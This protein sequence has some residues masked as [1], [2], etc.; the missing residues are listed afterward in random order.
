MKNIPIGEVLRE[1][2]YISEQQIQQALNI[3]AQNSDKRLGSIIIELGFITEQ[4]MLEALGQRLN[5]PLINMETYSININSVMKI[6]KHLAVKYKLIAIAEKD[7][8]LIVAVNDPLDFYAIEDIRQVTNLPVE[9][10]LSKKSSIEKAIEYYY[11]ESEAKLA[12]RKVQSDIATN[13]VISD[14]VSSTDE[15]IDAPVVKL[16]NSLLLRGYHTNVSDI[17]IEIFENKTIVRNRV[18]GMILDYAALSPRL[19]SSLIARIKIMANMDIAEKRLPQDGHFKTV[20]EDTLINVRVSVIPTVYGE[21]AVIRFLYTNSSI[22]NAGTFGMSLENYK[23]LEKLLRNP[24]GIIYLTG[25][26]GSGKTTT[27]YMVLEKLLEKN[28]NISTIEDPVERNIERINQMQV[29]NVSGLTFGIGL[30]ALLR[31]DPDIIMVGETRDGETASISVRA[32]ITGHLVLS[33]LHTNDAISTIVRLADMGVPQ[34]LIASSL[35]GVVAQRLVRK[36]C[37]NCKVEYEPDMTEKEFLGEDIDKVHKG[38]GCEYCNKTGY[39]GRVAIHEI[40]EIDKNIRRMITQNESIDKIY[41][42]TVNEQGVQ[43]LRDCVLQLVKD[44]ITTTEEMAKI[45]YSY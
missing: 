26:T 9:I 24:H 44:G 34:Y 12:V 27:L 4:Q 2:G 22:N 8:S 25:P 6:P 21:K 28:A 13:V 18:D 42:Y 10:R 43:T 35:V 19:H 33:T 39:K 7:G 30:R 45:A 1:L 29:N 36:I 17:H 41:D 40:V 3:Q 31:Q 32:A 14:D 20:I 16:L 23:K 11:S 15:D 37:P 38:S 5:L